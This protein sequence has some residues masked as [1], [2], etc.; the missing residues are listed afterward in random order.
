MKDG[1][2]CSFN[3]YRNISYEDKNL[4]TNIYKMFD[5]IS[6]TSKVSRFDILSLF[7]EKV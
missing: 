5:K 2:L 6:V 7:K 1:D 4:V 3:I